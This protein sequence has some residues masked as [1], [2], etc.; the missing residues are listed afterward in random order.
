MPRVVIVG[1]GISGLALAYRLQERRPDVEITVLEACD[2]PGGAVGTECRDGF[3][4]EMGPNGFLDG[5]PATMDL[6]R[7]LGLAGR[8]LAA[9][10]EAAQNRYVFLDGRLRALPNGPG[11]FL[12]SDLLSWR[13]KASLLMERFR[14]RRPDAGDES[15]ASF[16]RRRAGRE[17]AELLADALVTGIYAGDPRL[18]SVRA[19]FPRLP[20]LEGE[21][22]SIM[23]GL[24]RAARARRR[25]ARRRQAQPVSAAPGKMWSLRDG[26][27]AIITALCARLRRPPFT[28]VS[29]R[30]VRKENN[31]WVVFALGNDT[32]NADAVVLACPAYQQAGIVA[33]L[34]GELGERI[35]AIPYNRIAVVALGYRKRDVPGSLAGFGFIA[36]QRLGRDIL[37]V[38]WCSSIFPGRAP[39]CMVLLRALAGGWN[40]ADVA[41]WD[42]E[43][44]AAAVRGE[45]LLA[46]G[47]RAAPVFQHIV[48]WNRAIPQYLVG[49]LERVA[50]I[51]E[52]SKRHPGLFLAGSAYHGVALNDCTEQAGLLAASVARYLVAGSRGIE[53]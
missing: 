49:H 5:K 29:V 17:A 14:P 11:Q 23:K 21:H 9:S 19:C 22:G 32:L 12:L 3:Q 24:A 15:I 4:V 42:D 1:A 16:A 26:L 8:L 47:I 43:R 48:R 20:Q 46:Q 45:L 44:L 6:C 2:R 38:Q 51:E 27:G 10:P 34:D 36:P 40:R 33:D 50:W 25:Q 35:G 18:L 52:R 28:G 13:G 39:E 53:N 31:A 37:G 41:G 30:A 7:D